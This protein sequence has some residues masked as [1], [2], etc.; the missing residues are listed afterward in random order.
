MDINGLIHQRIEAPALRR[1]APVR[2]PAPQPPRPAVVELDDDST[3]QAA[4]KTIVSESRDKIRSGS[5]IHVDEATNQVVVEIVNLKNVDLS[6]TR[7]TDR[8]LEYL[9]PIETL[10]YVILTGTMVTP[11]AVDELR[12]ALPNADVRK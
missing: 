5:R 8:G 12:K 7:I 6:G 9:K 11:E 2:V 3:A 10:E 1:P 4:V